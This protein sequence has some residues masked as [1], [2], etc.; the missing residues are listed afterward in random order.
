M[1]RRIRNSW[2][3][4][5][6]FNGITHCERGTYALV[7]GEAGG[8]CAAVELSDSERDELLALCRQRLDD[9]REQRGVEVFAHRSRHR[10]PI[11]GSINYRVLTRA[12]GRCECCGAH[13]H[14]RALEVAPIVPR[15]QGG[16]DDLS[17]LQALCFRCN[18]G[19]RDT[20]STDF[21]GLQASYAL[22]EAG[23]VFCALEGSGRV[24][25]ENELALCIAD[26]YPVTPGHSLVIPRRHG[27]NGLAL[28]QPEWNA[29][30]EL[31][32]QRREQLSAADASISGWNV[33]LNSGEAAG[34]TVFHA[35]WHL[36]PRRRG[37]C[38]QPKGG[39]VRG[40]I[41]SQQRY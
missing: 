39:G 29:V 9:F 40:V 10:T 38:A 36:I 28:H 4:R 31:L 26:A 32:K 8:F 12:R 33:G 16:S 11:S 7:G 19:K 6:T 17:N 21:R 41:P 22:R 24:L 34:Q 20:D 1:A 5:F 37:D 25:L 14:Q 35:H 3:A 15:N 27:A 23:C 13:E 2:W 30:V 18:A